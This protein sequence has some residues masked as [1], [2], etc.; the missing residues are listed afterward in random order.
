[1]NRQMFHLLKEHSKT[2]ILNAQ[3]ISLK[4]IICICV[5]FEKKKT[6]CFLI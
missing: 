1:M 4:R 3:N 2:L 6:S 5:P